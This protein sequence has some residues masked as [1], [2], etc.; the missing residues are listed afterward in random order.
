MKI[1]Y[2][3]LLRTM[4]SAAVALSLASCLSNFDEYNHNPNETTDEEL[5]RDNYL[6]GSYLEA[7]MDQVI[8]AEEH[9]YQFIESLVGQP[10][11]RYTAPTPNGWVQ[12]FPRFNPPQPWVKALFNDPLTNV[13]PN[14]RG[15]RKNTEDAVILALADVLRVSVMHRVTDQ[16]GPI[17]LYADRRE[18]Q[19][20][21]HRGLRHAGAGVHRDV[22]GAGRCPGGLRG[23]Q[24]ALDRGPRGL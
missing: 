22:R 1:R 21:A 3:I 18:P 23:Q 20:S 10:Y 4:L 16:F 14:W 17:S 6:T 13:Y 19:G 9:Q 7:L 24:G 8:P 2:D 15:I 11:A 5:R 12:S